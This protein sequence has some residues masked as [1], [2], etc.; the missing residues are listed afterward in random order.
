MKHSLLIDAIGFA[1][2][3]GALAYHRYFNRDARVKRA[4]G[5]VPRG[6]LGSV[7]AGSVVKLVGR[8]DCVG[9]PLVAP[10]SRRRCAYY[11]LDI[12]E[13]RSRGRGGDW[14]TVV[15]QA[16]GRDFVLR[17]GQAAALVRTNAAEIAVHKDEQ[18]ATGILKAPTPELEALLEQHGQ[19]ATGL[20]GL[21][22]K[23]R[24]REGVLEAGEHVAVCGAPSRY[25]GTPSG[26]AI[27][28]A[29]GR[30]IEWV[31]DQC[32]DIPLYVSDDP[33]A[34]LKPRAG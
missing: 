2:A 3:G 23:L 19:K 26:A 27:E 20:L 1:I 17:D 18:D 29:G 24:F 25:A 21:N 33:V 4:L 10:L 30:P 9:E 15:R 28:A 8:L 34:L 14:V 22:R 11:E 16:S 12:E 31:F 13:W 7:V 32:G 6:R 5:K